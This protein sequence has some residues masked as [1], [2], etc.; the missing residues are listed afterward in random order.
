MSVM[1]TRGAAALLLALAG[2][3]QAAAQD[4]EAGQETFMYHCATCHGISG[5]G[6]GPMA[7]V[8]TLQPT[9]LSRL[10]DNSGGVFPTYD[11]VMRID[12]REPLVAHGSPMP[13]YG[14]FFAGESVTVMD[15]DGE[16]IETSVPILDLL[17]Y[18][19]S[20]QQE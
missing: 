2:A 18:L 4:A 12:G 1:I 8:L 5:Q 10:A 6:D 16:P 3:N 17:A 13:V 19:R 11:V 15:E 9:D 14:E 7:P 20:I